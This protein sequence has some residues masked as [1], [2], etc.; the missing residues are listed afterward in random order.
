MDYEKWINEAISK[1][2]SVAEGN[3]FVLRDLFDGIKWNTLTNGEKRE[4]GR[5]FKIKVNR[6]LVPNVEYYDKAQNNSSRY[7]KRSSTH[8]ATQM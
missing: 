8:V 5:Q 3:I 7:I 2:G 6:G 1:S 4:L